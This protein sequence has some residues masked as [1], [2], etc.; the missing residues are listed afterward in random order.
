ML[1]IQ[2]L[3]YGLAQGSLY[4]LL[5]A[6]FA[7]ICGILKM[8]TFAHGEVF[9]VGAFVALG[10]IV[11][12]GLPPAVGMAA[13]MAAAMALGVFIERVA[14]RPFRGGSSMSPAL[15]TIGFSIALQALVLLLAGADTKP[16]PYGG[17]E[18]KLTVGSVSVSGIELTVILASFI[19][20]ALLQLF[21]RKTSWGLALRAASMHFDAARLMGV[22]TNMTVALAFGL[23]SMLAGA[24]G[25]LFGAY[26]GAFYPQMG[27]VMAFKALAAATLG[28]ITSV[29]GAVAGGIMLGVIE[30]LSVLFISSGYKDIIAFSILILVLLFKPSG[31]LGRF[32]EEKV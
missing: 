25:L 24:G 14:F 16:F 10:V 1:I 13:A 18:F 2:T 23:A 28:G 11:G 31:L 21:I 29:S 12:L 20:V 3:I 30:S 17:G 27:V 7:L 26:Y 19:L 22:N 32:E 6:G 4:A 15:I 8:I 9:M 5:A